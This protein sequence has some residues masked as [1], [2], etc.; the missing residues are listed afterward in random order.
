MDNVLI[1]RANVPAE[2]QTW[3]RLQTSPVQLPSLITLTQGL[4]SIALG[5]LSVEWARRLLTFA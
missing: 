5:A 4:K 1:N 3:N 2:A